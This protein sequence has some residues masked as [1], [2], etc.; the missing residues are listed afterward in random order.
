MSVTIFS[1][2]VNAIV[3]RIFVAI[4]AIR[5]AFFYQVVLNIILIAAIWICTR[6][7]GAYGY[8]YAIIIM[9]LIN[10]ISMYFICRELV[11]H[12]K[13]E[14]LLKYSGFIILINA[15]IATGLFFA[16]HYIQVANL[17]KVIT[18]FW[19]YFI[20]LLMLNKKFALNTELAY[21]LKHVKK[22]FY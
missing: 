11:P 13:Y 1:I 22:K 5:Q 2:G 21:I 19:L 15:A 7:Y 8:A 9:N 12:I 6:Y 10:F 4:Q 17:V 18:G 16:V 3:T 14:A 20:I